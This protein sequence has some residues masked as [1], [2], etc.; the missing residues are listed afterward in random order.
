M[1]CICK[2]FSILY[3]HVNLNLKDKCLS[4]ANEILI[5]AETVRDQMKGGSCS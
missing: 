1:S 5:Y 4:K 3:Y 2:P